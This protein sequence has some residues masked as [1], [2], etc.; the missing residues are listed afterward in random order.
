MIVLCQAY[1]IY[2]IL[3]IQK[4]SYQN[5][6]DKYKLSAK[7]KVNFPTNFLTTITLFCLSKASDLAAMDNNG[8]SDPFVE[9]VL[10]KDLVLKSKV[11]NK[12]INPVWNEKFTLYIDDRSALANIHVSS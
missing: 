9:I 2:Q 11:I 1:F 3:D 6:P 7:Y 12:S 5:D 4:G 8:L 10:H